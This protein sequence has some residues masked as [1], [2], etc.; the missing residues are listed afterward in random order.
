MALISKPNTFAAGASIVASEHNSNYDTVYNDYN[1]NITNANC[2]AAMGLVDTKL[3]QITTASKVDIKALTIGSQASVLAVDTGAGVAYWASLAAIASGSIIQM[4]VTKDGAVSTT[5]TTMPIDDT[6]PQQVEGGP[7]LIR[8]ITPQASGNSLRIDVSFFAASSADD[9]VAAALFQDG[10]ADALAAG[11]VRSGTTDATMG[12][13]FSHTMPAGTTSA[14][15]FKVRGGT[16]SGTLTFNGSNTAV[17]FGGVMSSS[18]IV[19]EL[20]A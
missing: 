2:A 7:F 19:T 11:L 8:E 6:I 10:T 3:A 16:G 13:N 15:T 14:T 20:S 5:A 9:W 4:V 17:K 12:V 18:L 1:G